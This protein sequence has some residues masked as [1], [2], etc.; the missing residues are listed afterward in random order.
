MSASEI[1]VAILAIALAVFLTLAII[2]TVY[3]IVIAKKIRNVAESAERTAGQFENIVG[4]MRKAAAPAMISKLVVDIAS[5]F[6]ND[7]KRKNKKE[8]DD[9]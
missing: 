6:T 7:K 3:L 9:D 1:L 8:D 2:L 4:F 5:R